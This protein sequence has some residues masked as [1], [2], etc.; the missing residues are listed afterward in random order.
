M[1]ANPDSCHLLTSVTASIAAKIKDNEI[2]N[3]ESEKLLAV[4]MENK[5]NFNIHLQN[6]LENQNVHVLARIAPYTSIPK[7]NL[8]KNSFFVSQF[9]YCPLAWICHR[10]LM[11]NKTN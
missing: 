5:L 8:L 6:I 1:K 3:S 7:K 9:N 4:T 2:L 11:N 10:H